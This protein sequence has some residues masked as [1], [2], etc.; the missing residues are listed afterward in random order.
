MLGTESANVNNLWKFVNHNKNIQ[1]PKFPYLLKSKI[2][3]SKNGCC[4]VV[5][6]KMDKTYGSF[7]SWAMK[8]TLPF[9]EMTF[10]FYTQ[11]EIRA[12]NDPIRNDL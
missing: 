4:T 2:S 6:I 8:P 3:F 7:P 11:A 10:P 9:S 5:S 1:T 12:L